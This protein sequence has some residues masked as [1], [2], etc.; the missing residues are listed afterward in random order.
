MSD[1]NHSLASGHFQTMDALGKMVEGATLSCCHCQ[2]T[3]VVK[4][5]S[6]KLR[7]FCQNCNG[8]VCGP[9]CAECVPI[10]RRIENIE[11]GRPENTPAPAKIWVPPEIDDVK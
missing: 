6:G 3:W 9:A 4:R 5:G 1:V 11:A 10:E 7:G 2:A 8:F